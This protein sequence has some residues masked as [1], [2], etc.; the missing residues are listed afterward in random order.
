MYIG[1]G[2]ILKS[3]RRCSKIQFLKVGT[4]VTDVEPLFFS[5][6]PENW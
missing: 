5:L 3:G 6:S 2:N 1:C 4:Y